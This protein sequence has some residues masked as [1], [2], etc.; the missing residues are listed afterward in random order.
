[1]LPHRDGIFPIPCWL[2]TPEQVAGKISVAHSAF[3]TSDTALLVKV[4]GAATT[5]NLLRLAVGGTDVFMVSAA[6]QTTVS[7]RMEVQSGATLSSLAA[8]T[9][10]TTGDLIV[11]GATSVV[12]ATTISGNTEV[13]GN[14]QVWLRH[15]LCGAKHGCV[16]GVFVSVGKCT[17]MEG[18]GGWSGS[19]RVCGK[20][21]GGAVTKQPAGSARHGCAAPA[22]IGWIEALHRMGVALSMCLPLY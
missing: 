10:S 21:A 16:L 17:C 19:D 3:S 2:P 20:G 12:G 9:L 4:T 8:P 13:S 22:R 14:I 15:F 5:G 6:G 11:V 1:V 7:T 18:G